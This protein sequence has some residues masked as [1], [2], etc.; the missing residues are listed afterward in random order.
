MS[1]RVKTLSNFELSKWSLVNSLPI[2][3]FIYSF[4]DKHLCRILIKDI[5]SIAPVWVG[6]SCVYLVAD[7]FVFFKFTDT[8]EA[9]NM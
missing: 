8:E 9:I 4:Y 6:G 5:F 7:G 1:R 2:L 3:C